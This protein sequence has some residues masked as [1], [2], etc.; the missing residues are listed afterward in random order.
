MYVSGIAE[1][2]AQPA[3]VTSPAQRWLLALAQLRPVP[4]GEQID[5]IGAEVWR[6]FL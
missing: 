5:H 1:Q 6:V 4:V 3:M 2:T